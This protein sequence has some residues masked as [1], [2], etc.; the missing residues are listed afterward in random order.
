MPPSVEQNTQVA[1]MD[2][3]LQQLA[4]QRVGLQRHAQEI[5]VAL[6]QRAQQQHLAFQQ[7]VQLHQQQQHV[8]LQGPAQ[9]PQPSLS[10]Q[11]SQSQLSALP[12]GSSTTDAPGSVFR[13]FAQRVGGAMTSSG[14]SV[15]SSSTSSV[16]LAQSAVGSITPAVSQATVL[17][18]ASASMVIPQQTA[19]SV[20]P[21]PIQSGGTASKPVAAAA[22]VAVGVGHAV[23]A[24]DA[25]VQVLSLT[26]SPSARR[27]N[28]LRICSSLWFSNVV[29]TFQIGF[30]F[31]CEL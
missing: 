27:P 28:F 20:V 6:A 13:T 10:Q 25:S 26:N 7:Q 1:R 30:V 23:P 8:A 2:L 16:L 3:E 22:S 21:V 5:E 24:N 15:V 9:I 11:Q 19:P 12:F 31:V 17:P 29:R 18:S 14:E 4:A